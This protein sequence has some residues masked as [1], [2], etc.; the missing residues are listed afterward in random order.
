MSP[1][2]KAQRA[3]IFGECVD[4][5]GPC[6]SDPTKLLSLQ[7]AKFFPWDSTRQKRLPQNSKY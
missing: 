7:Q 4:T 1:K 6:A 2:V 5:W 3:N